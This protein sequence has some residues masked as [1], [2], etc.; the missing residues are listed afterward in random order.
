MAEK[1]KT[2]KDEVASQKR[3]REISI[4]AIILIYI[5]GIAAIG[6]SAYAFAEQGFVETRL[7]KISEKLGKASNNSQKTINFIDASLEEKVCTN[8]DGAYKCVKNISDTSIVKGY[9][10]LLTETYGLKD[11][12]KTNIASTL[13]VNGSVINATEGYEFDTIEPK[14][15]GGNTYI[16]ANLYNQSGDT[17][18]LVI[19]SSGNVVYK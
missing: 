14:K 9:T 16:V 10:L 2:K 8:T 11:G 5:V 15:F 4:I 7:G 18:S 17:Y 19:N 6:L 13:T 1:K 3:V 12:K